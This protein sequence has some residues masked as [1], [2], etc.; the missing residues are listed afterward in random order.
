M[1][2]ACLE[3]IADPDVHVGHDEVIARL[4][5]GRPR[6][7]ESCERGIGVVRPEQDVRE[8]AGRVRIRVEVAFQTSFVNQRP[9]DR[10]GPWKVA[11]LRQDLGPVDQDHNP[12]R[13]RP[14]VGIHR[15]Q[16]PHER[17]RV[18]AEAPEGPCQPIQ[19]AN[20]Q[21]VVGRVAELDERLAPM[22]RRPVHVTGEE[23]V[24]GGSLPHG[25]AGRDARSRGRIPELQH[26]LV[27]RGGLG[28]GRLPFGRSRRGHRR[29]KRA[30]EVASLVPVLGKSRRQVGIFG[31]NV[32]IVGKRVGNRR[33]KPS[34]LA[35]QRLLV[36]RLLDQRVAEA[37]GLADVHRLQQS[38][39]HA[40]TQRAGELV[41]RQRCDLADDVIAGLPPNDGCGT[42]DR[43]GVGREDRNL[44]RRRRANRA[45]EVEAGA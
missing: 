36:D 17:E 19:D 29:E 28:K 26:A 34:P 22:C 21:A 41:V 42:Q 27:V 4:D 9:G 38:R 2:L 43:S 13:W 40:L 39:L 24:P 16:G 10:Q 1:A 32:R 11:V 6:R 23:R 7:R 33:V 45:G 3:H 44:E 25:R 37:V 12:I 5:R 35:G 14:S 31:R 15:C 8:G 20:P 18:V 30:V